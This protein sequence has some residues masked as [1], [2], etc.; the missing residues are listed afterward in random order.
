MVLHYIIIKELNK[1][2][3]DNRDKIFISGFP[4]AGTTMLCLMMNYFDNC[5]VHSKAEE[6]PVIAA[7]SDLSEHYRSFY[8]E[9]YKKIY[10]KY[11]VIKQPFGCYEDFPPAYNYKDLI[12]DYGYKIIS[13]V[14][15][16]RDVFVSKHRRNPNIDWVSPNMVLRNCKEYLN[17]LDN[18]GVLFIRYEDLVTKADIEMDRISNFIGGA[19]SKDFVNFYKL[20][21]A[22]LDKNISLNGPREINTT[23]IGNWKKKEH[24]ERIKEVMTDELKYYIKKLGYE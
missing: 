8:G 15:D 13:M 1:L 12:F 6:H 17:N 20:P 7:S 16:P 14:R 3:V 24:E 9:I 18:P 5:D 4:R 19:Y 22:Q 21:D 2:I 11:L 23:S 10:K